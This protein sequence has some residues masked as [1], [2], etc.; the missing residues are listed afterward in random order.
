MSNRLKVDTAQVD[1]AHDVPVKDMIPEMM[2]I[3][4]LNI[5]LQRIPLSV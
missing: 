2:Y 1:P 5:P 3:C 4:G